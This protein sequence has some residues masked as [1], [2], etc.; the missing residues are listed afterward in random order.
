MNV[1]LTG[2]YARY[3]AANSFK[4]ACTGGLFLEEAPQETALPY[5]T[6]QLIIG[7][8][9]YNF[10]DVHEVATIQFDIYAGSNPVRQDLFTKLTALFDDC[11]PT[12]SGYESIIMERVNQQMLRE[13]IQ[14]EIFRYMVEYE[15]RIEK[16]K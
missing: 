16:A 13:G 5:A 3:D 15:I 7:R 4:T 6:Y 14:N 2:I 12:V 11:R 8:P 10:T 1:L 9:E